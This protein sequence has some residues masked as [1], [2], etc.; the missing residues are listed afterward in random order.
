MKKNQQIVLRYCTADG[1]ITQE[2]NPNGALENIAG[3]CNLRGNVMGL[4]PHPERSSELLIG[5]QDGKTVFASLVE[6]W[7]GSGRHGS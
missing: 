7:K 5:S 3:I 4:M 6:W 2:A 1:K